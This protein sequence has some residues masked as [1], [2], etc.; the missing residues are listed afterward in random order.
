MLFFKN[1]T[2]ANKRIVPE[3]ELQSVDLKK[4]K[5]DPTEHTCLHD[6]IFITLPKV[7]FH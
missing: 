5:K 4:K 3:Q 2:W 1:I 7:T 6:H